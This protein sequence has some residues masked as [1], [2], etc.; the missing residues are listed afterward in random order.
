MYESARKGCG[1]FLKF[2]FYS[3]KQ[4]PIFLQADSITLRFPNLYLFQVSFKFR[5]RNELMT[6]GRLEMKRFYSYQ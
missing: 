6:H 3:S 5:H 2:T 1:Y 4:Y